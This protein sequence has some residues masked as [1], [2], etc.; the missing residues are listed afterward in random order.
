[1]V[2]AR[3]AKGLTRFALLLM[4][5]LLAGC[6]DTGDPFTQGPCEWYP[7]SEDL[8]Q[9][10]TSLINRNPRD[11]DGVFFGAMPREQAPD[12]AVDG[13][14]LYVDW[15]EFPTASRPA[16][17]TDLLC[18]EFGKPE[19]GRS[20]TGYMLPVPESIAL[21]AWWAVD[22]EHGRQ[23][24]VKVGDDCCFLLFEG[25]FYGI[26]FTY[27]SITGP[28][29]E[30]EATYR[31]WEGTI[32]ASLEVLGERLH[33]DATG[34]FSFYVKNM[35]KLFHLELAWDTSHTTLDLYAREPRNGATWEKVASGEAGSPIT[36]T[37]YR[38]DAST[39][40]GD[41][42]V[43]AFAQG[44]AAG[45]IRQA[46]AKQLAS[47][48]YWVA[49]LHYRSTVLG[50]VKSEIVSPEFFLSPL[51]ATDPQA[52]LRATLEALAAPPGDAPDQHAR[53]RFVARYKWLR[54]SLD[55]RGVEVP[56][57]PCPLYQAYTHRNQ[58]ESLSLVY[59]TGYL[60]NPASFYG[61][62]LLKFNTRGGAPARARGG[63][64]PTTGA[65]RRRP[66]QRGG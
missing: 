37:L 11:Y 43:T 53:C 36:Y 12:E 1:M 2:Q 59:A 56:E 65:P 58:I 20:P 48:P 25:V 14:D 10:W 9:K 34:P 30:N 3:S 18:Y 46:E 38:D 32:N 35:S 64:P 66:H 26:G 23:T 52:E 61:H 4:A 8:E 57:T 6:M 63:P 5:V 49:L 45:L 55:W 13:T 39:W 54:Q 7:T 62:I 15:G 50:G 33:H 27:G 21:E 40:R 29:Y 19:R 41:W 28:G 47:H 17:L 60:S 51:G 24:G 16:M 31:L 42:E 44:A 22:E